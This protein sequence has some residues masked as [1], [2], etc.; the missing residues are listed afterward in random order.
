MADKTTILT[1][2]KADAVEIAAVEQIFHTRN[3]VF[4]RLENA[5]FMT[6]NVDDFQS[7]Y[8]ELK[9]IKIGFVYY[10]VGTT[11]G[12]KLGLKVSAEDEP[13]LIQILKGA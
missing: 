4:K 10:V 2:I 11:A 5:F 8:D 13:V 6:A 1:L 3:I 7:I 12:S 9:P